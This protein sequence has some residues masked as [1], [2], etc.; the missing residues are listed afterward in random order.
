MEWT[1]VKVLL[2]SPSF[3]LFLLLFLFFTF[4]KHGSLVPLIIYLRYKHDDHLI[5]N[6]LLFL[7][8]CR[9]STVVQFRHKFDN[10]VTA[11]RLAQICLPGWP[12]VH[13]IGTIAR[14]PLCPIQPLEALGMA[15][16]CGPEVVGGWL[17][18]KTRDE[19]LVAPLSMMFL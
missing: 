1:W 5:I 10:P 6:R 16:H 2:L 4:F 11:D 13:A 3:S 15:A 17:A 12:L 14:W 18:T 8:C 9:P 7:E 19:G